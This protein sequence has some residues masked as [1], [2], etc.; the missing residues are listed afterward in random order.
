MLAAVD[1]TAEVKMK[2]KKLLLWSLLAVVLASQGCA[3][4]AWGR[5][6]EH[7]ESREKD[8]LWRIGRDP[9]PRGRFGNYP[10]NPQT[11]F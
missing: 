9:D 11:P 7:R 6:T 10:V 2:K 4:M 3:T 1:R 8:S 5:Y